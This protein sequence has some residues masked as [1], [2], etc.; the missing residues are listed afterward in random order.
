MGALSDYIRNLAVFLIFASFVSI[1]S[2]GKKYEQYINLALGV[3]L[4][5]V[6]IAPLSG[7]VNALAGS[8]GDIFAD[9]SLA[10]DRHALARQIEKA[11]QAGID[12][13]MRMYTEGLTEQTRRII[14]NHGY[15]ALLAANFQIDQVYDFG[16]VLSIHLIVTELDVQMPLVRIE[17]VRISPA[18]NTRGEPV[19]QN[20]TIAED[21]RKLSLKNLLA[22]FYNV[23]ISNIILQVQ[24]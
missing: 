19:L 20:S 8:S 18:I 4:I 7:V 12:S 13:I 23:D 5:L 6:I 14:E 15:F 3:I 2:P 17:E 1:I 11:D 21:A 9:V 16:N 22:S 24:H 10:Y